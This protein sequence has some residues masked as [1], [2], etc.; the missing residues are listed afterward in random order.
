[1]C[2]DDDDC[3]DDCTADD[4]SDDDCGGE[5]EDDKDFNSCKC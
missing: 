1:M 5:S 2:G 3:G 4:C